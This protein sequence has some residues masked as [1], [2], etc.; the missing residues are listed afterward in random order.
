[1]FAKEGKKGQKK[2]N[3]LY[4]ILENDVP[5]PWAMLLGIFIVI[6]IKKDKL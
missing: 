5:L 1:M 2:S 6:G 3:C 4:M